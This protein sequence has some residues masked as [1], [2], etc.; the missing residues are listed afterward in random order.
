MF[1]YFTNSF[2]RGSRVQCVIIKHLTIAKRNNCLN[3]KKPDRC[4]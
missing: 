3:E 2:N 1:E 4:I